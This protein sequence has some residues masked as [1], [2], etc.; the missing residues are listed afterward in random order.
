MDIAGEV[1]T[2][3]SRA[4]TSAQLDTV[5]VLAFN[6]GGDNKRLKMD[7]ELPYG[8]VRFNVP[9]DTLASI[10]VSVG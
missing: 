8:Y 5:R 9:G 6:D 1:V 3:T 4:S 10:A 2:L 7:E